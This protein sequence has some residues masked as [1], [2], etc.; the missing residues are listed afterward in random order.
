MVFGCTGQDG[1]LACH[2]LL[3]R[4]YKV[5]GISR[6]IEPNYQYLAKLGIDNSF[7]IKHLGIGQELKSYQKIL[8]FYKPDEIYNLAAQSSVSLSFKEPY[9]CIDSIYTLTLT[10]LEAARNVQFEGNL[11]FAGSSEIFGNT[12]VQASINHPKN[13]LSPY[14]HAK[15]A[16]MQLICKYREIYGL[17]CTIGI[18][19]PH[20]S[21]LRTQK[22]VVPKIIKGAL[23]CQK[24]KSY[25]LHLGNINISRDW[26]W[27]PDYV[28]A[29]QIITRANLQKDFVICTGKLTPLKVLIEKTFKKLNMNWQDYVVINKNF[30]RS[31]DI[32]ESVGDPNPLKN[33]LGWENKK[34]IDEIIDLLLQNN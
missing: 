12:K 16:S 5:I 19:F 8:D 1:S 3:K 32:A 30:K 17:N 34:N 11:F 14:A 31:F 7:E 6:N 15:E 27:A 20:E 9:S 18:L 29:M 13:C 24:D 22:F 23:K 26:G 4:G 2:S 21:T 28:E 33:E 25:K 10:I